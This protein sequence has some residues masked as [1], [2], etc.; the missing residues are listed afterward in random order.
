MKTEYKLMIH[1]RA[2]RNYMLLGQGDF[3]HYL[4]DVLQRE[5]RDFLIQKPFHFNLVN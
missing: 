4:L 2:M 5:K 1:F 3:V